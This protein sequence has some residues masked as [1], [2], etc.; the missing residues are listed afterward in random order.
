MK[1]LR[2][3][4][5]KN[6]A[7]RIAR[8]ISFECVVVAVESGGRRPS[9]FTKSLFLNV[10]VVWSLFQLW[11]ASPIP[12]SMGWGVFNSTAQRAIHL[13]IA[14]SNFAQLEYRHEIDN[15]TPAGRGNR[16][17]RRARAH[18]GH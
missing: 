9:G 17:T 6:D 3:S 8:G 5:E 7:L 13:A 1:P 4:Q 14:T 15:D 10:A 11:I 16:N 12:Y 2:W 18:S